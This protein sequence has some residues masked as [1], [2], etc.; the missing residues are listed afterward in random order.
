TQTITFGTAAGQV[1]TD[2]ELNAALGNVSGLTGSVSGTVSSFVVASSSVQNNLTLTSS[3]G[4]A[5]ALGISASVHQH[6][7]LLST[8]GSNSPRTSLQADFNDVI[9]QIDALA[10]DASYNGINL[11]NGDNLKVVFNEAGT[12]SLTI[13]G[14]KFDS[15][16]LGL[17][18]VSGNGFQSD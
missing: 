16:G 12:S 14:V 9:G 6:V 17:S 4:V 10:K 18:T 5:T 8:T 7:A 13:S 2:A 1:S 15:A 11:L 3:T